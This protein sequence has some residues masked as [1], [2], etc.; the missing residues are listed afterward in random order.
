MFFLFLIVKLIN[1]ADNFKLIIKFINEL[2]IICWWN[3]SL[4]A[5][6]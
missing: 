5:L 3:L 4:L 2:T 6:K 1:Q